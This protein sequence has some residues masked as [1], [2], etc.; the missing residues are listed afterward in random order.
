MWEALVGEPY[1]E[2]E[3]GMTVLRH[4]ETGDAGPDVLHSEWWLRAHWGRAFEILEVARPPRRGDG[5]PEVTHS[6]I[7]GPSAFS[8]GTSSRAAQ[9]AEDVAESRAVAEGA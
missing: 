7:S 4:W 8:T 9:S 6:Y 2:D 1:R 3:V 5:S